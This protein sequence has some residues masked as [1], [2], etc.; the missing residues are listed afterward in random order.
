[1]SLDVQ[2]MTMLV[3]IV[4]GIYLGLAKDTLRRFAPLWDSG[5][6]L[7]YGIEI[8]FWFMQTVILYYV[9]L[10]VNAGELRLI[11]FVALLLGFSMYQALFSRVYVKI[12]ELFIRFGKG[13]FLKIKKIVIFIFIRAMKL[14]C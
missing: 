2:F 11:L 3:M 14:R 4:G 8:S 9:L 10:L 13:I 12:L 7:K 6:F 1:M 5:V